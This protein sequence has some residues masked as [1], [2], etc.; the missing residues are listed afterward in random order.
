MFG[1]NSLRKTGRGASLGYGKEES[2]VMKN[3]SSKEDA[4]GTN[5]LGE[6]R[7]PGQVKAERKIGVGIANPNA[8][9][10][11][12]TS[13][14]ASSI[15]SASATSIF[16][17][18]VAQLK[19]R[20]PKEYEENFTQTD[21]DITGFM[22]EF[23]PE[24][25]GLKKQEKPKVMVSAIDNKPVVT[26]ADKV[27]E[28]ARVEKKVKKREEQKKIMKEFIEEVDELAE[29]LELLKGSSVLDLCKDSGVDLSRK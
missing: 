19:S 24:E 9:K 21:E 13:N 16:G 23:F 29:L 22:A 27:K 15:A 1:L 5:W 14:S 26:F 2:A 18:K 7:V 8:P 10:F 25:I 6:K 28:W 3:R 11:S 17:A 12:I 20:R 4:G